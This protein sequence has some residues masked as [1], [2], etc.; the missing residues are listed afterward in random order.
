M[1][2]DEYDAYVRRSYRGLCRRAKWAG[3]ADD[4]DAQSVV[5]QVLAE[6]YAR[7][8]DIATE[9]DA[10]RFVRGRLKNRVIDLWRK[11][12]SHRDSEIPTDNMSA[13]D[14]PPIPSPHTH[15]DEW[16][17]FEVANK[18]TLDLFNS[19]SETDRTHL[20]LRVLGFAPAEC[21]A[22]LGVAPGAERTRWCR[23]RKRL[24]SDAVAAAASEKEATA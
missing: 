18:S 12:R 10:E 15:P 19:L 9:N 1:T 4:H 5:N 2:D 7:L 8:A 17:E 20:R 13:L 6:L 3:A 24:E 16:V 22:F 14:S 23:L 21:A 11:E